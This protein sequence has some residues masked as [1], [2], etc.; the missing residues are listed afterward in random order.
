MNP[1]LAHLLVRLYPAHWRS[2]YGD[3][4]EALLEARPGN[5]GTA[6]NVIASALYEHIF[7]TQRG[8]TMNPDP[9]PRA[10]LTPD[11]ITL[12]T[13]AR[14]PSALLPLAM[15][16]TALTLV[17]V[18]VA[19]YGAVREADEGPT[20]HLW[21]ILMAAQIPVIAFFALKSLR[22]APGPTLKVLTL[23][24]TAVLANIAAVFSFNLG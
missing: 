18:H 10:T 24:A 21:Q 14:Q 4:F 19:I 11:T 22:Q 16:L 8:P 12:G 15:S 5:L 23:Q 7:P 17:L 1:K 13:I 9:Q 3:E 2:R 6:A 20:A